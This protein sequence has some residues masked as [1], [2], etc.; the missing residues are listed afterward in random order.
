MVSI[1]ILE[2]SSE[3][4]SLNISYGSLFESEAFIF[5]VCS[6]TSDRLYNNK[7]AYQKLLKCK[8]FYKR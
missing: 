7:K 6:S 1:T 2:L 5:N 3:S 4:E 8:D